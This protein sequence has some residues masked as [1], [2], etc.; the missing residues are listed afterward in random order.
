VLTAGVLG[1]EA[2]EGKAT[3]VRR[4][5]P[6]GDVV[7]AVT[8]IRARGEVPCGGH[9]DAVAVEHAHAYGEDLGEAGL[10][11]E[12]VG[13]QPIEGHDDLWVDEGR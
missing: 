11:V 7:P 1:G 3:E 13:R 2:D 9:A 6:P 4:A 5:A 8:G 12:E 10:S